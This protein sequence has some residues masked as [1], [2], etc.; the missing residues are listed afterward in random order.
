MN[1]FFLGF[2][3]RYHGA[4]EHTYYLQDSTSFRII[5]PI[6]REEGWSP[7]IDIVC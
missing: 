6:P 2:I 7:E 1:L 3:S 5:R 4:Q